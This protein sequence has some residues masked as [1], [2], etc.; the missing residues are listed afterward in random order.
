MK[1]LSYL[2]WAQALASTLGSIILSRF[3]NFVPCELCWYQRILMFPLVAIIAVG[4]LRKD[5]NLPYY[6]LPLSIAGL[7]VAA[8]HNLLYYGIISETLSPCRIDVPCTS[9]Q[10][11]LFGFIT[12]PLLSF[13]SF[14]IIT[15]CMFV[16]L[17]ANK[18]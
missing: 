1:Y 3:V 8:Y 5:K 7:L 10:L 4:I 18:K 14:A 13:L 16:V 17:K 12:I 9:R 15:F 6:A 2:A 11:E